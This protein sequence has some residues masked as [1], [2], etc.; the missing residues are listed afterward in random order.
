MVI[1]SNNFIHINLIC[2]SFFGEFKRASIHKIIFW[3][4]S[5]LKNLLDYFMLPDP[6]CIT[7]CV[8]FSLSYNLFTYFSFFVLSFAIKAS[9]SESLDNIFNFTRSLT[10]YLLLFFS[11]G[12]LFEREYQMRES[13][14]ISQISFWR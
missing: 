4:P 9:H 6:R 5:S 2:D 14:D 10:S 11:A 7:L 12:F 3:F 1:F 13:P 8:S